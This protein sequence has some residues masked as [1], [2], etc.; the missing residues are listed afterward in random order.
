MFEFSPLAS[1]RHRVKNVLAV[2]WPPLRIPTCL[3][4]TKGK[5]LT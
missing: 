1:R 2:R 4:D 3:A 5:Y